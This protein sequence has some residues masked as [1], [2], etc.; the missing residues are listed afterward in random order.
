MK[1]SKTKNDTTI[2]ERS[3]TWQSSELQGPGEV[4]QGVAGVEDVGALG[5]E[6]RGG[7]PGPVGAAPR[8]P[9]LVPVLQRQ[10]VVAVVH[11]HHRRPEQKIFLCC[12]ENIL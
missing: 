1:M 9:Q 7:L 8:R 6:L 12:T 3:P 11:H 4:E 5:P 10:V 2:Q